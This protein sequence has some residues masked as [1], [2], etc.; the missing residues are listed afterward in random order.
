MTALEGIRVLDLTHA[1]AGPICTMFMGAE[2]IKI[3]PTWGEMTRM[4]PPLKGQSPYFMFVDRCKKGVTL[5]LK[6]PRGKE[7]FM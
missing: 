1:H 3:E 6:H 2:V 4:F 5:D 7:L